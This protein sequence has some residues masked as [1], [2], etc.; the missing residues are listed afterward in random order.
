MGR[1]QTPHA[2]LLSCAT[3]N[4]HPGETSD[5]TRDQKYKSTRL[6]F[7]YNKRR[8][9]PRIFLG[10]LSIPLATILFY[11]THN[12]YP[13][14]TGCYENTMMGT[15]RW[16]FTMSFTDVLGSC[17]VFLLRVGRTLL[18]GSSSLG[19]VPPPPPSARTVHAT[20]ICHP[21]NRSARCAR[22][23]WQSQRCFKQAWYGC[24]CYTYCY[25]CYCYE[26]YWYC[27]YRC[28]VFY[29]TVIAVTAILVL[30]FLLLLFFHFTV[31]TVATVP[32]AVTVAIAVVITM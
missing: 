29:F 11:A 9:I 26:Y 12:A 22:S 7:S 2:I 19:E 18:D 10:R 13:S 17:R 16:W 8:N 25:F 30:L 24:C 20:R 4:A 15:K 21:P 23:Y 32:A 27:Y 3:H 31:I 28:N 1:L 14:E 5:A 6:I